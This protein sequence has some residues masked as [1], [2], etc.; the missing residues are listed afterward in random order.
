MVESRVRSRGDELKGVSAQRRPLLI[1][2]ATIFGTLIICQRG[3][4]CS[5]ISYLHQPHEVRTVVSTYRLKNSDLRSTANCS[6]AKIQTQSCLLPKPCVPDRQVNLSYRRKLPVA[7]EQ[8]SSACLHMG[9]TWGWEWGFEDANAWTKPP[10][11]L[12]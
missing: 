10:A 12:I 6:R 1:T 4:I 9:T 5:F 7:P 11:I 8:W 3:H 2:I